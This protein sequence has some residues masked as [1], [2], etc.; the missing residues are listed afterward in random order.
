MRRLNKL[1]SVGEKSLKSCH[2]ITILAKFMPLLLI[3]DKIGIKEEQDEI[4]SYGEA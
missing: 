3:Y 1:L 2:K 4:K